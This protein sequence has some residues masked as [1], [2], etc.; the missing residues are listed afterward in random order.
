MLAQELHDNITQAM[1]GCYMEVN[2]AAAF[3]NDE[4]GKE[5]VKDAKE[6]LMNVIRDVRLLSHSLATGM[7]ENRPLDEAIQ[8]ELTRVQTFTNIECSLES[9]TFF[10]LPPDERLLLFRAV[11]EALQN[12][13]KHAEANCIDVHMASDAKQFYLSIADNGKGFDRSVLSSHSYGLMSIKERI[14]RLDGEL[15]V[16]SVSGKGTTI[17]LRIPINKAD[18]KDK[19]SDRRRLYARS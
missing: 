8:A 14:E 7:V 1:T 4:Q 19:N 18:E 12:A 5:I 17:K 9:D 13:V 2:A 16:V 11:Q 15:D 10:E 6:H 3:I